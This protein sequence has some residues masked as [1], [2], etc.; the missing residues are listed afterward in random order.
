MNH[1]YFT[2]NQHNFL[3]CTHL[4]Q[5]CFSF[6]VTF[7]EEESSPKLEAKVFDCLKGDI[8][9][10]T[11]ENSHKRFEQELEMYIIQRVA[12]PDPLLWWKIQETKT[13][14]PSLAKLANKVLVV[15]AIEVPSERAFSVIWLEYGFTAH[16]YAWA[17]LVPKWYIL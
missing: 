10:I 6:P 7:K 17:I 13:K 4:S 11:E 9:D 16:R 1:G 2:S 14:F 5:F 8:M 3:C 12:I 15:P